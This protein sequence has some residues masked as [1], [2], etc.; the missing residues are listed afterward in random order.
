MNYR[1]RLSVMTALMACMFAAAPAYA[2]ENGIQQTV[3]AETIT[4][5]TNV[6]GT[7]TAEKEDPAA[8]AAGETVE[9]PENAAAEGEETATAS[10]EQPVQGNGAEKISGGT[11]ASVQDT[12]GGMETEVPQIKETEETAPETDVSPKGEET[13]EKNPKHGPKTAAS[14]KKHRRLPQR[15]QKGQPQAERRR[16]PNWKQRN[17]RRKQTKV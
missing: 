6:A 12:D 1:F 2:A 9:V 15:N 5:E 7:G 16:Q 13:A 17:L 10:G 8:T 3:A 4:A 11:E 14:Q